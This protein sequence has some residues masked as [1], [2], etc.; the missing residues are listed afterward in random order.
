MTVDR[1][2]ADVAQELFDLYNA[3]EDSDGCSSCDSDDEGGMEFDEDG[4]QS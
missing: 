3:Q 1:L 2:P 4:E